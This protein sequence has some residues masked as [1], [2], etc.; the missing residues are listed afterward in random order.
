MESSLTRPGDPEGHTRIPRDVSSLVELFS[1]IGSRMKSHG[2][3]QRYKS[4]VFLSR[5]FLHSILGHEAWP[6]MPCTGHLFRGLP[7]F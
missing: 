6:G 2:P 1:E 7:N 4:P 3:L 5:A